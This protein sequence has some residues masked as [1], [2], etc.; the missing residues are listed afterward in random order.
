MRGVIPVWARLGT[1]YPLVD[2]ECRAVGIRVASYIIYTP[3][4]APAIKTL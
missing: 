1:G 3:I 4:A 2:A